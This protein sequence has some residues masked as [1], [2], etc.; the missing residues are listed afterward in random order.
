MNI[1]LSIIFV[2]SFNIIA[3]DAAIA[4]FTIKQKNDKTLLDITL[5]AQDLA[6]VLDVLEKELSS[7]LIENYLNE[8]TT[9]LFNEE[10][11]NVKINEIHRRGDHLQ[12]R[13]FF[14][15]EIIE[16]NTIKIQNTCLLEIEDHSNIIQFRLNGK[17]RD[18]RMNKHRTTIVFTA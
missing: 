8:Q 2:L 6:S 18:F 15:S 11:Y 13:G 1:I 12:I 7:S 4:I 5:D 3:H 10:Q 14:D 16:I 9:F 17:A